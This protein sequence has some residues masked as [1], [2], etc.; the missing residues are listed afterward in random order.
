MINGSEPIPFTIPELDPAINTSL[1]N[2]KFFETEYLPLGTHRLFVSYRSNGRRSTPLTLDYLLVQNATGPGRGMGTGSANGTSSEGGSSKTT[3]VGLIVGL[4]C[5]VLGLLLIVGLGT[6]FY[7]RR[8]AEKDLDRAASGVDIIEPFTI[9]TRRRHRGHHAGFSSTTPPSE[10]R[11]YPMRDFGQRIT[12]YA[13]SVWS[14]SAS[15]AGGALPGPSHMVERERDGQAREPLVAASTPPIR[16]KS[17]RLTVANPSRDM[18]ETL[19]YEPSST[20]GVSR[21]PRDGTAASEKSDDDDGD[22]S[23]CGGITTRA[24]IKALEAAAERRGRR[25]SY[26]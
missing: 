9:S 10:G 3:P 15:S 25:D 12:R 2:Q 17:G 11:L 8:K 26:F 18:S 7:R 6:V 14:S 23:Y 24:Q 22:R 20:A 13:R 19:E 5:G 1:S 21:P 4:V 16:T